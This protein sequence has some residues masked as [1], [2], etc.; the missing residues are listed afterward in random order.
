MKR[1]K[2]VMFEQYK[3]FVESAEKTSDKRIT[4]NNIYLTLNLAFLSVLTLQDLN[5]SLSILTSVV[6]VIVCII[7]FL[8][9]I[10]YSKRN[11]VKFDIINE[12]E[13]EFNDLYKEE[14][15]RISVLTSLSTYERLISIIF[16]FV[17]IVMAVFSFIG[18]NLWI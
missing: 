3:M 13:E 16:A 18:R 12:L 7:W 15:K 14:W 8:T 2:E 11:K 5:K 1:N 17:Y 10:N 4:Q 6:G 9:I